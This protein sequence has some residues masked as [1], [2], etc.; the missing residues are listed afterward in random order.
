MLL[1][2]EGLRTHSTEVVE[3][4]VE[5]V[6]GNG[7]VVGVLLQLVLLMELIWGR[8]GAATSGVLR[9]KQRG[10][11]LSKVEMGEVRSGHTVRAHR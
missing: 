4:G 5:V 1:M 7:A 10:A 11:A 2:V 6:W 3:V 9:G 8:G